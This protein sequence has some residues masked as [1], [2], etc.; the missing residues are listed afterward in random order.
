MATT[1]PMPFQKYK[2]FEPL[3]L[4]LADRTWPSRRLTRAPAWCLSLIHI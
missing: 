1:S 2:P 4:D 3:A